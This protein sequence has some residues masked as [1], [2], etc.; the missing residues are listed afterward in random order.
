MDTHCRR[1]PARGMHRNE[2][3]IDL[4]EVEARTVKAARFENGSAR[5]R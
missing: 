5:S 3:G 4:R 2:A 1:L